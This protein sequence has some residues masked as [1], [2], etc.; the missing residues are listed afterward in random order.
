MNGVSELNKVVEY[1]EKNIF[2]EIDVGVLAKMTGLS[3]YEF[4]RIFSF[5]A[6][7]PVNEYIRKRRMSLS[8]EKILRGEDSVVSLSILCGYDSPSSFSRAFKDFHGFSPADTLNNTDNIKTFTKVSF[9]AQVKGGENVDY[10]LIDGKE[11]TVCG[12]KAKSGFND[13]EC[14]EDV[15]Q[16]YYETDFSVKAE[17]EKKD[18]YALYFNG[19]NSV[20]CLIGVKVCENEDAEQG[21]VCREENKDYFNAQLNNA[22]SK[23]PKISSYTLKKSLWAEFTLCGADDEKVNRFYNEVLNGWFDSTNYERDTSLPNLE[24]FPSDMSADDFEWKILIPV[25]RK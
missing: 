23:F 20:E 1:I 17:S 22:E 5:A 13:T 11:F 12:I 2:G 6:G 19:D 9:V 8:A 25:I 3:V 24:I 10:K 21:K 7:T 16:K 4:R 15:W 14:C 18:V